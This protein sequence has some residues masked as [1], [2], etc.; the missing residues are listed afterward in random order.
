MIYYIFRIPLLM[1]GSLPAPAEGNA[2]GSKRVKSDRPNAR[3]NGKPAR[4]TNARKK[5]DTL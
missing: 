2:L 3:K 1:M 5:G 4:Q